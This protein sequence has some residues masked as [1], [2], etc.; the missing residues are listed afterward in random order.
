M[1][2]R[3][4]AAQSRRP[5]L[6]APRLALALCLGVSAVA[7]CIRRPITLSVAAAPTTRPA[8]LRID[9]L[10]LVLNRVARPDG[11]DY[12]ALRADPRPLD[13]FLAQAA[14]FGPRTAPAAFPD[15]AAR[16]A[17]ALN[18]YHAA[19]LRG[20]VAALGTRPLPARLWPDPRAVYEFTIDGQ[21]RTAMELHAAALAAAG[22]D[23]RVPLALSGPHRGDPPLSPYPFAPAVLEWQ[24]RRQAQ[25]ALTQPQILTIDHSYQRLRLH[26]ALLAAAPRLVADYERRTG[27]ADA[28]FLSV[29]LE[30]LPHSRH[31]ELNSSVG[32][33]LAPIDMN[34]ALNSAAPGPAAAP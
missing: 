1:T 24:L 14:G 32:Y 7:G 3:F 34:P 25:A 29:L 16:L 8:D 27:A 12:D 21:R 2:R 30:V 19:M 15:R 33:E 22:D 6:H 4:R 31:A 9:A 13:R 5:G 18:V 26:P 11:I 10:G 28:R 23:W 17:Y 20:V